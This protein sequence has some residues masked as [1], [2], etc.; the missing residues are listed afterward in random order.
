MNRRNYIIFMIIAFIAAIVFWSEQKSPVQPYSAP[1][2]HPAITETRILGI[3]AKSTSGA[4]RDSKNASRVVSGE[5]NAIAPIENNELHTT[6]NAPIT[7]YGKVIDQDN[8]PLAGVKVNL[9]IFVGYMTSATTGEMKRDKVTLETDENGQFT[10]KNVKGHSVTVLSVEKNGYELSQK[11]NWFFAYSSSSE[12]F[13]PDSSNPVILTM[14]KRS[15]VE[16]LIIGKKFYG[17]IPDG[18]VYTIDFLQQKKIEGADAPGD[19]RVQITRPFDAI[20]RLKYD[21]S[22]SIEAI[23][24]GLIPTDDEFLYRAPDE[25][26][27]PKYEFTMSTNSLSWS[28][29]NKRKQFYL[30][31]RDGEVYGALIIDVLSHYNDKSIFNVRYFINPAGSRNLELKSQKEIYP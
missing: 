5:S 13:H 25:G 17:I 7:F 22:F 16:P 15:G 27:Q 29:E 14:W 12:I 19:I 1:V 28:E 11:S 2:F 9:E 18:R 23:N 3:I 8:K 21:W 4:T 31:S 24:G 10:L 20:P 6:G 30:R 26:Y